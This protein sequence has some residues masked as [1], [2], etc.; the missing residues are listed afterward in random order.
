MTKSLI[1]WVL[2][3]IPGLACST[4]PQTEASKP[5]V[6]FDVAR[7]ILTRFKNQ[8]EVVDGLGKPSEKSLEKTGQEC[9]NYNEP[10]TGYQRLTITF[11]VDKRTQSVLWIPL[12]NEREAKLDGIL[13]Q[14]QDLK[15]SPIETK[16][17]APPHDL[18]TETIFS[19]SKTI[20]ILHSDHLKRVEAVSWFVGEDRR[21]PSSD[22]LTKKKKL[23]DF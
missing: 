5:Q 9:W 14:Y 1:I 2:I 7:S 11:G 4:L 12:E 15:I 17:V 10:V 16:E 20:S 13:A 19:D 23:V 21:L 18:N 3:I 6:T 22:L 8:Q